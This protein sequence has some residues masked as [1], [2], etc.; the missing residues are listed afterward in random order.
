[1]RRSCRRIAS[2]GGGGSACLCKPAQVVG[3]LS[4]PLD[5]RLQAGREKIQCLADPLVIRDG[6]FD[7]PT[8]ILLLTR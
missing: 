3:G 8:L 1:M 7:L 4:F 6:H 5:E 2:N